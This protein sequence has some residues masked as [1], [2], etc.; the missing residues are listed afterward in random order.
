MKKYLSF[1]ALRKVLSDPEHQIPDARQGT[2]DSC[3]L[4]YCLMSRLVIM[5]CMVSGKTALW[6]EQDF[7]LF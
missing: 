3:L 4:H 2:K 7:N 5:F 1:T 6:I